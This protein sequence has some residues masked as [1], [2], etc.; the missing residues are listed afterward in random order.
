MRNSPFFIQCLDELFP[1]G[2]RPAS[3]VWKH[4][5]QWVETMLLM[6]GSTGSVLYQNWR[7]AESNS[8]FSLLLPIVMRRQFWQSVMRE[9]LRTMIPLSTK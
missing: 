9:R 2:G 3:K 8:L 7:K 1:M 4:C 5:F 6:G